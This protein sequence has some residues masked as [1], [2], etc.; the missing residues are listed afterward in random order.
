MSSG[1]DRVD[2]GGRPPSV[3]PSASSHSPM[4]SVDS[5]LERGVHAAAGQRARARRGVLER[6][7]VAGH[8]VRDARLD[9]RL[10]RARRVGVLDAARLGVEQLERDARRAAAQL[11]VAARAAQVG[12]DERVA[13][14]A[15][16]R[17]R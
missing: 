10:R 4:M 2:A 9:E 6:L 7:H 15:T 14:C 16:S 13:S 12:L 1:S 11:D 5:D 17:R 8:H 3:R